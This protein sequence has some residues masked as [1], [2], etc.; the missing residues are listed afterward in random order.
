MFFCQMVHVPNLKSFLVDLL[1][2]AK[3]AFSQPAEGHNEDWQLIDDG[4]AVDGV[5]DLWWECQE[6]ALWG[7]RRRR[8]GDISV[9]REVLS[10]RGSK[11]S[12]V[13]VDAQSNIPVAQATLATTLQRRLMESAGSML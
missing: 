7:A 11:V 5:P 6:M 4:V 10:G 2:S 3:Q 9:R 12:K 1:A 13:I 8:H